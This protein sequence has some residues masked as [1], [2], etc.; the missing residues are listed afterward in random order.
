MLPPQDASIPDL[1]KETGVPKDTLYGW[2]V[3][4]R[5]R[6]GIAPDTGRS[7]GS[8]S[9]E[10]KFSFLLETA[11]LNELEL[12]EY[13]RGKG[14]F[15]EQIIRWK[16]EFIQGSSPEGSKAERAQLQQ[17][18]KTIKQL[19][20]ELNRKDRALAEAAALLVL[21]K[22]AQALWG[23]NEDEKSTSRSAKK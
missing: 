7:G 20:G 17:Q 15:P 9:S 21:G 2:R 13:C 5:G 18:A 22:K 16:K 1:A 6:T 14:L 4:A 10:E 19:Q 3:K 23:E 11:I 8:F 12:G